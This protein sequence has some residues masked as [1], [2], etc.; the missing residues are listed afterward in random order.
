VATRNPSIAVAAKTGVIM[1]IYLDH[2]MKE[3]R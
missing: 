2:A 3:H 1:L